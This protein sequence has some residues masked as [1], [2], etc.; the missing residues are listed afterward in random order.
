MRRQMDK[1]I[2]AFGEMKTAIQG[3]D[4]G[5]EGF[6]NRLERVED[7][8]NDMSKRLG[9]M[10]ITAKKREFYLLTI[11]TLIGGAVATIVMKIFELFTKK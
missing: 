5:T 8:V 2:A 11:F 3:N 7:T 1:M 9:D 4:M 6:I 10:E